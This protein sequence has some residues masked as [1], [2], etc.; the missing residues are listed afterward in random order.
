MKQ[1]T[2]GTSLHIHKIWQ[3]HVA[4]SKAGK[5]TLQRIV[6]KFTVKIKNTLHL[7]SNPEGANRQNSEK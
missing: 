7:Q 1:I 3:I 5:S 6:L 4:S 2:E